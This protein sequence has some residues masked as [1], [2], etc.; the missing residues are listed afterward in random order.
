MS[1]KNLTEAEWKK[2]AKGRDIKDAALLKALAAF[3]KA[4][5]PQERLKALAALEKEADALRKLVKGDKEFGAQLDLIDKALAKEEKQAKADLRESEAQESESEEDEESPALLTSKLIPLLRQVKKGET[6]QALIAN[7]GKEVAVLLSRRAIAPTR[8]KLLQDYL[9]ASTVKPIAGTCIFEENAYTFVV[10]SQAS[11]LAKKLKAALLAQTEL[12]LKVR[13]RGEDGELDDDGEPAEEGGDV[14]SGQPERESEEVSGQAP[15]GRQQ[16]PG[17]PLQAEYAQRLG[18]LEP[19]LKGHAQ[20]A[21]L[22]TLLDFA[23]GKAKGGQ[24]RAALQALDQLDKLLTQPQPSVSTGE[25]PVGG[26]GGS[27]VKLQQ[28]RLVWAQVR[29]KAQAELAGVGA[30]VRAAVLAHNEDEEAEDEYEEGDLNEG[31]QLLDL[32]FEVLDERLL[33]ALDAALNAGPEQRP[34]LQRQAGA[35]LADYRAFMASSALLAAIDGNPFKPCTVRRNLDTA[36]KA[37]AAAL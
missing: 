26:G 14:E 6:M 22:Q 19:R 9:Q 24:Y 4:G 28:A 10:Q 34:A 25:A 32:V 23:K 1:D 31:V 3:E 8:R 12:R 11:G 35:I 30:A 29:K 5:D 20:L 16:E 18:E 21:K 36:L 17:D 13:V 7:A 27:L 37:V 2:F 33:D 15:T